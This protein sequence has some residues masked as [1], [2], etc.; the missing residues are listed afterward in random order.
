MKFLF[1]LNSRLP[2]NM[3]CCFCMFVNKEIPGMANTNWLPEPKPKGFKYSLGTRPVN[4][5][6]RSG[7]VNAYLG[8][9]SVSTN[10]GPG[11]VNT[12]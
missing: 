5:N 1:F 9:G 6:F 4:A 10:L 12:N 7:P 11:L 2:L 8:P 3:F